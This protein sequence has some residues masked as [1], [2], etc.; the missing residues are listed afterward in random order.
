M[1]NND[2]GFFQYKGGDLI[3]IISPLTSQLCMVSHKVAIKYVG[4]V[5]IYKIIDLYNYL[6]MTLDCKFLRGL[7]KHKR[8]KPTIVRTSHKNVQN[9]AELR[10]IMN[11]NLKLS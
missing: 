10:Q 3:Y 2:R 9:L 7:F 4:P 11:T 1:I 6:L 8:L 5:E